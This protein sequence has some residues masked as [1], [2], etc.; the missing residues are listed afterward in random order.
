MQELLSE[1]RVLGLSGPDAISF[2]HA[3]FSSDVRNLDRGH[4]QWSAWLSPQG[5]VRAFFQLLRE[6][7]DGLRLL[8]RGGNID[9]LSAALRQYVLRAKVEIRRAD[10][11]EAIGTTDR[12]ELAT[13]FGFAPQGFQLGSATAQTAL[14]M[15]GEPA[16]W[17]ILRDRA[18]H[19]EPAPESDP[20]AW[21]LADIRAGL[22][23]LSPS[24]YEQML[25]SWLGLQRLGAVSVTKGCY[26]GQ[27]IVSR[28]H[29]KGGSSRSLFRV[30][31]AAASP[32]AAGT[33]IRTDD[34]RRD[35]AGQIVMAVAT[36]D[37]RCEAL[38]SLLD[39][40]AEAAL[41]CDT[42]NPARVGVCERFA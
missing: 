31:T 12:G 28:M 14:A 37:G 5:R 33:R 29:F 41:A 23:R 22:P 7:G 18:N 4:W 10:A 3:Q 2:A 17:L 24:L 40:C 1:P 42:D 6:D 16:R 21:Q 25:P 13:A 30:E 15:P 35:N 20:A 26:P 36:G 11:I 32:P 19:P 34:A 27:E 38:A 8:L 39:V 9:E